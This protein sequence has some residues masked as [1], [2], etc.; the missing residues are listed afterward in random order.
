MIRSP[1]HFWQF[2]LQVAN[3]AQTQGRVALGLGARIYVRALEEQQRHHLL[4]ALARRLHQRRVALFVA[5]LER[6]APLHQHVGQLHVAAACRQRQR[7]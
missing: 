6:G 2:A 5:L 3:S 1:I 4:V 7:R